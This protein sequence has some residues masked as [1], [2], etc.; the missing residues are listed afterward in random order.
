MMKILLFFLAVFLS[1]EFAFAYCYAPNVPYCLKY[2]SSYYDQRLRDFNSCKSN[3]QR[4][5]RELGEYENCLRQE[6]KEA[7]DSAVDAFNCSY[8]GEC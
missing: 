4:Y 2:P 5:L 7:A 6:I 8:A 1:A 3:T